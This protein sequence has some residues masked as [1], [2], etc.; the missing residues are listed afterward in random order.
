MIFSHGL[1]GSRNAYSHIA[2][3]MASHGVVVICPEH[4]DGSAVTS[5]VRDPAAQNRHLTKHTRNVIPYLR[6]PH[7]QTRETW[8]ARNQQLKVRLWE[9][10]L[11][12]EAILDIDSGLGM[13]NLNSSTPLVCLNQLASKLNVQEPGS[14]IFS[15]HSFGGATIVQLL[16][17][18]YYAGTPELASIEE[19]L[20]VPAP[21][22]R[23]RSQVTPRTLTILL[24]M[25][26]FPLVSPTTTALYRLPL[27]AYAADDDPSAP[28]GSA[29]LAVESGA[30]VKW[31]EHLHATC[32][33]LSPDPAAPVVTASAFERAGSGVRLPEP[34]F[35]C[36]VDSAHLNQSD[37]GV[38]FPWLTKKVFASEQPERALRLNV[39]ALLQL[40]RTNGVPVARTWVGDLVDGVDVDAK[41]AVE[42]GSNA[43]V[44]DNGLEDG[45]HDDKTI[46]D[47]GGDLVDHWKWIDIIGMGGESG[48]DGKDGEPEM[49]QGETEMETEIEMGTTNTEPTVIRP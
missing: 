39:R 28:G 23:I 42:S 17:S 26:C 49:V 15:G 27:P 46:F 2:G 19:P 9:L 41:G 31:N 4:R 1:G 3:S 24:D 21:G 30:F 25:W 18:T 20:F 6:I 35:F 22:S 37:F 29:I 33:V 11:I 34:N 44:E 14:I 48:H 47:R 5:F 7:D 10:G 12:H 16:K 36:V 13:N 38:L 45:T 43:D 32:R 40:L 8:D